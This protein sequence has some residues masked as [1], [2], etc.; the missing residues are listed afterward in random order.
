M[1]RRSFKIVWRILIRLQRAFFFFSIFA[2]FNTFLYVIESFFWPFY[3]SLRAF[4]RKRSNLRK[5]P[6]YF[7]LS[8]RQKF[9]L[10][11]ESAQILFLTFS[12]VKSQKNLSLFKKK[13][14]KPFV[15]FLLFGQKKGNPKKTR[16]H[17]SSGLKRNGSNSGTPNSPAL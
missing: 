16:R 5:L 13:V 9:A 17:A 8:M 12:F 14:A 6:S 4:A 10:L 15:T 7:L 1:K 11:G 3:L 2:N